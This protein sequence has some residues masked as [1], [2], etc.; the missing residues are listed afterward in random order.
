MP[1]GI[2][3]CRLS[4]V[5]LV[6]T[7]IPAVSF[8]QA[9]A[10]YSFDDGTA[11]DMTLNGNDGIVSGAPV[12]ESGIVNGSLN[13]AITDS[14]TV[15]HSAS[16]ELATPSLVAW[17]KI[18]GDAAP[19]AIRLV[20]KIQSGTGFSLSVTNNGRVRFDISQG[21]SR[22]SVASA[23][24]IAPN[25][26]TSI[27]AHYDGNDLRLYLH[28]ELANEVSAPGIDPTNTGDM[29]IAR[30]LDGSMDEIRLG[31]SSLNAMLACQSALKI[32]H[33][34]SSTCINS[35]TN[36]APAEGLEDTNHRSFGATLVDIDQDGW[37]D[38]YYV[39]GS[40]DP[41]IDLEPTGICPELPSEIPFVSGSRN[42]LH[43][44]QG[45]GTFGPDTAIET[46]LDDRWNAMR[47]AWADYD[48]D[49]LRD[50]ISHNFVL[51]N[52]Y[53]QTLDDPLM[54]ENWN[55]E[56]DTNI[57]LRRGTGA[58]WI[59]L[60]N[61]GFLD[62]HVV[63]YDPGRLAT[64]HL[65]QLYINDGLG[66][67]DEVIAQTGLDLPDNPMGQAWADYDNDGDQDLYQTNSHEVPTRLYRNN[68]IDIGTGLPTFTDVASAAGVS[69]IGEPNRGIG[70]SWGDYNNDRRLDLLFSRE[71][72][73][74]LYRNDG[75]N[76]GGEWTFTDMSNVGG[77]E[78][79]LGL[80]F[81]GGG[82][83]DLNNDGW[84][85][86]VLPNR[87]NGENRVLYNNGDETWREVTA[88]LGMLLETLPSMGFVAGDRDN[89]GDVDL[90]IVSHSPVPDPP[91]PVFL[92]DPN[93]VYVNNERGNN[94]IQFRLTGTVSNVE[95]VGA[96]IEVLARLQ[97]G[98]P[99]VW[100]SR[101]INA[102]TGFFS[103]FPR[104]QTFGLG[105]ASR[106]QR[107]RIKWPSGLVQ[108]I[109]T[110]LD[111]NQIYDFTEPAP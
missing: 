94:W 70:A 59:D 110:P 102:G 31:G 21:A 62:L 79:V 101:E 85:D 13:F 12:A 8:G 42:A 67:F 1:S 75:P 93:F 17:V 82:F 68:G 69:V 100:Q 15:P 20:Q 92:G 24:G 72:D 105:K 43:M 63:E 26:W 55:E 87:T 66:G 49:G 40:G 52:L 45:D 95:A 33:N 91:P 23:F 103:D 106:V 89:D 76:E 104:I 50:V 74:R 98:G 39:N 109:T 18:D 99:A 57:C 36:V 38:L 88:E 80:G 54:F 81:W 71:G 6:I 48:R 27:H 65:T 32:W 97:P 44:N 14:I 2:R 108:D 7:L 10:W 25:V 35:F 96:R 58:S 47:H 78:S 83:A 3:L 22:A 4:V 111:I 90:V 5:L 30:R 107:A 60:T 51:T 41:A 61:D 34:D 53:K 19:G 9:A 28:G 86:I 84:L 29:R 56:S 37:I 11:D 73:S 64:D 46:G 16:L 77:F